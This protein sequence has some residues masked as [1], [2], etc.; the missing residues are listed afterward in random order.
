MPVWVWV[1]KTARKSSHARQ[2]CRGAAY[3]KNFLSY[4]EETRRRGTSSI[5]HPKHDFLRTR[6]FTQPRPTLFLCATVV[7][8][9]TILTDRSTLEEL[10]RSETLCP[11]TCKPLPWRDSNEEK[12]TKIQRKY[13]YKRVGLGLASL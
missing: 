12:T 1:R 9:K 2:G 11:K 8:E 13:K 5:Y 3:S 7:I 4:H 6:S 10:N